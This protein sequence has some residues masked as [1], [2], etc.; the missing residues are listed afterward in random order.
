MAKWSEPLRGPRATG[1]MISTSALAIS[2]LHWMALGAFVVGVQGFMLPALLPDLA[3]DLSVSVVTAGQFMTVFTLSCAINSPILTAITGKLA[4]RKLLIVSMT[5]FALAN[6]FA[7]VATSY[8][9]LLW[10][11]VFLAFAA[12]LYMP[13]ASALAGAVVQPAR[14]GKAL[15]TVTAG[16]TVAVAL[17][18]PLSAVIGHA[19]GWR[20]TFAIVGILALLATIGFAFGLARDLGSGMPATTFV[21]RFGVVRRK[22]VVVALLATTFWAS[23]TYTIYTYLAV[24]L[25]QHRGIAHRD[26]ALCV[27]CVC[28]RRRDDGR[29]PDRQAGRE[30][31]G[32]RKPRPSG[33]RISE[34]FSLF[35]YTMEPDSARI[36]I[37]VAVALWG[38]ANWAFFP[39]QQ[40]R[41][42]GLSGN[43]LASIVISLNASLMFIGYSLGA[44]IGSITMAHGSPAALGWVAALSEFSSL[45]LVF[46]AAK[47]GEGRAE[48]TAALEETASTGQVR[49]R[50]GVRFAQEDIP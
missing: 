6:F 14:R 41:L 50:A 31:G 7:C 11:R 2:P 32:S 3:A 18:V 43:R 34:F 9:T 12:G 16:T 30:D 46:I 26:G 24:F 5:A 35:A 37:L 10:A 49:G 33:V 39:A 4:R 19:F 8:W 25:S 42:I 48:R 13:N 22:S 28:G 17:G 20:L 47:S 29:S 1:T 15:A 27:G 23:G 21:E 36:P 40:A 38:F 44:T 45:L